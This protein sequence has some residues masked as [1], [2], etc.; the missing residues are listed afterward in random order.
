M[1]WRRFRLERPSGT[2]YI[3]II[4][5]LSLILNPMYR[6]QARPRDDTIRS[7][8]GLANPLFDL[9]ISCI[10]R[11]QERLHVYPQELTI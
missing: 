8:W 7:L 3:I 6:M 5:F 9:F 10:T 1:L 4:K 2:Y 11:D